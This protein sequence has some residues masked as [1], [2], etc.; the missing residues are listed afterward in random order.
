VSSK[1]A[2]RLQNHSE[3][4]GAS[5][6]VQRRCMSSSR[7]F[8]IQFPV[9]YHGAVGMGGRERVPSVWLEFVLR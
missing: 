3:G 2:R 1:R 7:G 8:R 4:V 6:L 5:C 9:R